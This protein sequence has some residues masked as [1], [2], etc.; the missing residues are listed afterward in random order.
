MFLVRISKLVV[1]VFKKVTINYL[2]SKYQSYIDE[3]KSIL[4][5]LVKISIKI[6]E[7][8]WQL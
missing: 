8:G 2:M 3:A 1:F 7:Y 4:E 5:L 6:L